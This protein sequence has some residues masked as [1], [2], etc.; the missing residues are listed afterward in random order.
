MSITIPKDSMIYLDLDG[1]LADFFAEISH[2]A[3]VSDYRKINPDQVKEIIKS[4]QFTDFF[5]RLPKFE[6]TD[7]IIDIIFNINRKYGIISSPLTGDKEN[8]KLHKIKWIKANLKAQPLEVFII[9]EKQKYALGKNMQRNILIDDRGENITKWENA[10]G[11][12]IKFQSDED[13]ILTLH[14]GL[15]RAEKIYKNK[16][17]FIPQNLT[18]RI[19]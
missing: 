5:Y 2:I 14:K 17:Q 11:I 15:I 10:G 16:I 12:G 7:E 13:N 8:S 4:I 1:V 6:I 18:S 3:G 9:D 19:M